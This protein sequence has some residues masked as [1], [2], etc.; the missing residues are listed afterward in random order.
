ML[1]ELVSPKISVSLDHFSLQEFWRL[2][3]CCQ[4]SITKSDNTQ[5]MMGCIICVYKLK[6]TVTNPWQ[7]IQPNTPDSQEWKWVSVSFFLC[8]WQRM[9]STGNWFSSHLLYI[10]FWH[11]NKWCWWNV[12]TNK[13]T[14]KNTIPCLSF[15]INNY[16]LC[17]VAKSSNHWLTISKHF[18]HLPS[19]SPHTATVI[20]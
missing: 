14:N 10:F 4:W 20:K 17:R 9:Y 11:K 8:D 3:L 13:Q 15:S 7:V 16:N 19:L 1:F 18:C 5:P 12:T 2:A 6:V